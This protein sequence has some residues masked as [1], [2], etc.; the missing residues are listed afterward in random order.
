MLEFPL[1]AKFEYSS[2]RNC[3][4]LSEITNSG[5]PYCAN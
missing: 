4:P 2:A 3:G 1:F 5:I